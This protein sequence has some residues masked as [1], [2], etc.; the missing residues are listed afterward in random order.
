MSQA[1]V[2][3]GAGEQR[4]L[5]RIRGGLRALLGFFD[6]EP[7]WARQLIVENEDV[8]VAEV[9]R[10]VQTALGEVLSAG[11]GQVIIGSQLTPPISLIAELLSDAVVSVIRS[12]LLRAGAAPLIDLAPSL[13]EHV[14]DPYLGA[15]AEIADRVADPSLPERAPTEAKILPSRAHPRVLLA[16]RV[17]AA[18]PGA[19]TRRVELEVKKQRQRGGELSQVLNALEQR[20]MIENTPA[21]EVKGIANAW[22]LTSYGR[23]ALP[24][25]GEGS[26]VSDQSWKPD[27]SVASR[28]LAEVLAAATRGRQR[29]A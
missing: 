23:R 20:G 22:R 18:N 13:M 15:G 5:E 6:D 4:W 21:A 29:A 26:A 9:A 10:L 27:A 11:R 7:A 3:A 28:P 24:L 16:L 2:E 19:S 14:V 8:A 1:V 25:L 12:R 17:I